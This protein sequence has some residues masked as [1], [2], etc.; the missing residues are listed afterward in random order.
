MTSFDDWLEHVEK[1]E[2]DTTTLHDFFEKDFRHVGLGRLYMDVTGAKS[3][4]VS[5]SGASMVSE[6]VVRKYTARYVG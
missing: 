6:E 1:L 2:G 5:L 4:S 3:D